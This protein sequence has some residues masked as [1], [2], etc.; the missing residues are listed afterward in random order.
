MVAVLVGLMAVCGAWTAGAEG[1]LRLDETFAPTNSPL[2][3]K[4]MAVL[5][6]SYV[7]NHR[8][9]PRE[10]WHCRFAQKHGMRY[11]NYG[12]NGNCMVLDV[13]NRGTPMYKRF[14]EI[15]TD[16]DYQVV[17]AGH[18]DA[19]QIAQLGGKHT[20]KNPT[21][22]QKA[23]Q[24]EM[25]AQFKSRCPSFLQSLKGRFPQA[26]IAFVTPW[27]VARPF[28]PEVI[29]TIKE[30]T[31]AAGVACY[32]A[33]SLADIRVND[34]A[35]RKQYFQTPADTAHLNYEGHG[36]MLGKVE[37]FLLETWK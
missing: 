36:L 23:R 28:F 32:D 6:D 35:F 21:E 5:G 15:S 18:N 19:C 20:I 31:A 11:L 27:N 17:I 2:S 22:E 12:R 33:A 26:K 10:T 8:R 37:P 9:S 16:I 3:G 1:Y 30:T 25:L 14:K 13:P 4:T 29:A 24:Q 34:G 7:Q